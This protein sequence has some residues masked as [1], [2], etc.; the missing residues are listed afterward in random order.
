MVAIAGVALW[1]RRDLYLAFQWLLRYR[2]RGIVYIGLQIAGLQR[3]V[4]S[5]SG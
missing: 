2:E 3:S 4:S 1:Y 5:V